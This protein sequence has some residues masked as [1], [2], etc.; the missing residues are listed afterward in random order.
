MLA[1]VNVGWDGRRDVGGGRCRAV[2]HDPL[3][4]RRQPTTP[5]SRPPRAPPACLSQYLLSIDLV[6]TT[7]PTITSV[8]LPAEGTTSTAVIDRFTVGFSEDMAPATVNNPANLTL[9]DTDNNSTYTL[10]ILGSAYTSGLTASYRVVDG[11]L[12]P[13]HYTL[14][15]GTGLTDQTGNALFQPYVRDFVTAGVAPFILERPIDDTFATATSLSTNP[16]AAFDGSFSRGRHDAVGINPEQVVSADL[17][18]D[19]HLDLV[20]ANYNP[21]TPAV[22]VL[23]GNGDGTFAARRQLRHRQRPRRPHHRRLQ[24]RRQARHHHHQLTGQHHQRPPRQRRRHL[25]N[26]GRLHRPA[27]PTPSASSPATSTATTSPTSPSPTMAATP[28][29][30]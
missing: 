24:Q 26:Q 22:S 27:A 3:R 30:S 11:P 5:A 25:R 6:N 19:N 1:I 17:N 13:G 14:T 9:V 10:A 12:Q 23:L 4:R 7:P 16:G 2:V 20:T 29:E 21:A 18:K 28:S 8:S 15:I